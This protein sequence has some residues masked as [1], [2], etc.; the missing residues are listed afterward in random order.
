MSRYSK[1]IAAVVG[2]VA[3]SVASGG[4]L[5]VIVAAALGAVAVY[6]APKNE[7]A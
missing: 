4:D 3:A 1:L 5:R 7:E 6:L 2:A